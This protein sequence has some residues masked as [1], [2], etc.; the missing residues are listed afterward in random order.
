MVSI[1]EV[2]MKRAKML[3]ADG[4]PFL[5]EFYPNLKKLIQIATTVGVSSSEAERSFSTMKRIL[6]AP[7][8]SMTTRRA[9]NMTVISHNKHLSEKMSLDKVLKHWALAKPRRGVVL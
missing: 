9:T 6:T 7:R 4:Q 8:A 1:L 2:E 5:M 3:I